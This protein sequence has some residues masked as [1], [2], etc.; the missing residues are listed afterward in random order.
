MA[1]ER[2]TAWH[3]LSSEDVLERLDTSASK[4]LDWAE[5]E[6]RL[7]EYGPNEVEAKGGPSQLKLFLLQFHQP[8][9]YILIVA[10]IVTV[11]LAEY[12]DA[13]VIFG[14]VVLIGI[15]GYIQEARALS[16]L[17]ALTRTLA[18]DATVIRGGE[19]HSI[20]ASKL[21]PGDIVFVQSGDQVPADLRLLRVRDL[22]VEEA[23][24]TGESVPVAK[25]TAPV[26]E[27]T[28]LGDRK[29]MAFSSTLVTYGQA[30][31]VVVETGPRTE[32][33]H[34]S[35]LMES[36]EDIATPLTRR[37]AWFSRILLVAILTLAVVTFGLGLLH[38]EVVSAAF[39]AAVAL[40]V[41]AIPEGLPAVVTI[42][43]AIGVARMARQRAIIRKLPAVET[44]G[45][46]T[47]ICSDKTGTLTE[48]QMTVQRIWS[49]GHFYSISGVG[50]QPHGDVD[51]ELDAPD[52]NEALKRCLLAGL[53]CNDSSLIEDDQ[54]GR[55]GIRG[56][57]TE[58]ALLVS[59][60]KYGLRTD[61]YDDLL[62]RVDEVP[63]ES[64][65][66]YMATLHRPKE[67]KESV[68][69]M[70]GSAEA[71]VQ[72]CDNAMG[73]DGKTIE[74][75]ADRVLEEVQNLASNGLRVLAFAEKTVPLDKED[76]VH[77]DVQ[78]RLTL[79]GLQGMIDPPREEA[80]EAVRACKEAG[81][82][83]KMITGD[84]AITASAI[85]R[86]LGIGHPGTDTGGEMPKALTGRELERIG[87]DDLYDV[88]QDTHVFARIP[89]DGKLR[90]V[91]ALQARSH[92][93]AMT[94][95][96][97]NDG[98]ALRQAD[99]GVAMGVTGTEVAK[100]ASDMVLTDD[101]FASI[102][103]AVEEGRG[104]FDNL[105]KF[106]V[107]IL[108][109]NL[110]QALV[111]LLAVA[112]GATLPMLPV[113]VLWV[114]MTT[115][116]FLG[117]M[118]AFEPKEPGIMQRP[119]R[120][121]N[122]RLL[123]GAM[124]GRM[125]IVSAFLVGGAFGLFH[126]ADAG[127]ASIDEARTIAVNLFIVVQ[128]FYLLNCRSMT[129]SMFSLGVFSNLWIVYG[130]TAMVVLQLAFTYAPPLNLLFTTEPISLEAWGFIIGIGV[131]TF[132]A[133]ELEKRLRNALGRPISH[134]THEVAAE[135]RA[136]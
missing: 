46:T 41:A 63:F 39:L 22:Q 70:K 75:D 27:D 125:L 36:A 103:A 107:Y 5:A 128:I 117:L 82:T 10:G 60:N 112:V 67:G 81:I 122:A 131:L 85:A 9:I 83:V 101:N 44:L 45:S 37:I 74:L 78:S 42:T 34:I 124:G 69:F 116:V 121:P 4:G 79:V 68:I 2:S 80:I 3:A 133:I 52:S 43:L 123:T 14:V 56:D 135:P 99:I 92:V 118:L 32:V 58:G 89:P 95:D 100:E 76:V 47:V 64:E 93:V 28:E 115:A 91:R 102:E 11:L 16:A 35:K 40:A 106:L 23:A 31:G 12:V 88:A 6:R 130:V 54:S 55:W 62:Q 98:P 38:G 90:L 24:F 25:D 71:I 110:G 136:D 126:W 73:P 30:T 127:G 65:H 87:D 19:R 86:E 94:G 20:P 21:V 72:R 61:E 59:A 111:I 17:D 57:P 119:P 29:G 108:P 53:M 33:G 49:G 97:V 129:K 66:Q 51:P 77:D 96:G 7:E 84:H 104:V 134:E 132:L 26:D 114:N 50:Y 13:S 113:H 48:N 8:L 109:T 1:N 15:V 18:T 105:T 120:D